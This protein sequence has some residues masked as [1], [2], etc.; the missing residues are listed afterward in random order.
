LALSDDSEDLGAGLNTHHAD[1]FFIA[2]LPADGTYCVHLGDTARSGGEAHGYRLRISAPQPDFAL[3]VVPSS[4]S[5]RSKATAS[6]TLHAIRRDGFKGPIKLALAHPPPGFSATPVTLAGTQLVARLT[7]KTDLPATHEPVP[8][9]IVGT[10]K[11]GGKEI[12]HDAVPAEDRMQAFLWRHLVPAQD[13]IAVV[14]DPGAVPVPKR[15]A[16]ARPPA[17]AAVA[18]NA[19]VAAA[20][21]HATAGTNAAVAGVAPAARKPQFTKQQIAGRLRQLKLLFEDGLLTDEFYDVKVAECE[22]AK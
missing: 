7:I 9:S 10:A 12:T 5:L 13:M 18:T 6:V 11:I 4:I 19:T 17:A 8:L 3:R 20:G 14:F 2:T 15:I 16:R 21:I 1:S 22:T